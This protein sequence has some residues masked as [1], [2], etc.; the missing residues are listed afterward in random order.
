MASWGQGERFWLN[1]DMFAYKADRK[2]MCWEFCVNLTERVILE[3]GTSKEKMPLTGPACG[4]ACG[5]IS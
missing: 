3:E 5:A 4:K 2:S 1:T